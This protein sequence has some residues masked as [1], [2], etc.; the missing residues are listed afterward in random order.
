[1]ADASPNQMSPPGRLTLQILD[2]LADVGECDMEGLVEKCAPSTW[3][4]V[5]FEVDRLTRTGQI[6][7]SYRE[8]G[9][10]AV[11]LPRAA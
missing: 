5:F 10:Y 11:S 7:L 9:L 2:V 6:R 3:N 1:M 4:A 8:N